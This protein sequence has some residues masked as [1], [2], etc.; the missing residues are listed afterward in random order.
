MSDRVRHH[1]Y[2]AGTTFSYKVLPN[3]C[4]A[5]SVHSPEIAIPSAGTWCATLQ[6]VFI[7][8]GPLA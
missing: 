4:D 1:A 2:A 5:P 7:D 6:S 3:A 8:G